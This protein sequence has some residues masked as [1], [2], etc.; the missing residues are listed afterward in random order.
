M[1]SIVSS[2]NTKL[3]QRDQQ[4]PVTGCN[5]KDGPTTCPL[6]PAEC[7]KDNVIYVASVTSGEG[8]E[9]YTGLTSQT[10][11]R[12]WSKHTSNFDKV[13]ERNDTTLSSHIWKLKEEGKNF[14][15]KWE[16]MDRAPNF[17]PV[18][19]KC[20]LC[21]KEIEHFLAMFYNAKYTSTH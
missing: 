4:P 18:N 20:R 6:T 14:Q 1:V 8:V 16:I 17:N 12:R 9:H 7:Q 5:C 3:L 11:K 21:L 19:R 10:F 15:I 2:H 13:E